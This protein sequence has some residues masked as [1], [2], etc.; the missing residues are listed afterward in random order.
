MAIRPVPRKRKLRNDPR[1]VVEA[2]V[3]A[4]NVNYIS[5]SAPSV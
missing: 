2:I 3:Y 5:S 1:K 4:A